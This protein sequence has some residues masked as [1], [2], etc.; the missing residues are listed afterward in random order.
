MPYKEI[1]VTAVTTVTFNPTVLHCRGLA[2]TGSVSTDPLVRAV[3]PA[4][5]VGAVESSRF[6]RSPLETRTPETPGG[7]ADD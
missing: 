2:S 3:S 5:S 1:S 7:D 4:G 6:Q